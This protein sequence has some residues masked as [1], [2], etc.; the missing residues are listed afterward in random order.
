MFS[1]LCGTF[2]AWKFFLAPG[3]DD[4]VEHEVCCRSTACKRQAYIVIPVAWW[5]E[6]LRRCGRPGFK[7]VLWR[8]AVAWVSIAVGCLFCSF[9]VGLVLTMVEFLFLFLTDSWEPLNVFREHLRQPSA[10]TY[11]FSLA[12][13]LNSVLKYCHIFRRWRQL[14]TSAGGVVLSGV[15]FMLMTE[16]CSSLFFL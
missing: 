4:I 16:N 7:C 15:V 3:W 9:L 6:L 8:L 12:Q 5:S 1:P 14:W 13:K 10:V 11:N 2:W